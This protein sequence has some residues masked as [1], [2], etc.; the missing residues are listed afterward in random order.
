MKFRNLGRYRTGGTSSKME[1]SVP[2]PKTPEGRVYRFSPNAAAHPRHFVI[3][4]R[5]P[6][7][8]PTEAA[9][10]RMKNEPGSKRTVCPYS[11]MIDADQ[12]FSHPDDIK[13]A[14]EIVGHAAVS[15]MQDELTR[16]FDGL[17][18]RQ[19][20]NSF[21]RIEAK[22]D[23][24]HRPK[25]RFSRR[26]LMRALVCDHCGRDYGVFAIG[27]FCPDCGAPN[28]RLHFAREVE[29][30]GAQIDLA[31]GSGEGQDEL[32]YR[33]LGNAHEDVLTA[34]EATLK[35]VYLHGMDQ[36]GPDAPA[37]KPVK[38]DFQ[39]IERSRK[40][41]A[42]LDFD[43]FD[44]LGE[45]ELATLGLNIQ[46]RHLIGHNL[47]VMDERFA[48]FDEDARI[49]ETVHLVADDIRAFAAIGQRVID[50]LDAWLGGGASPTIGEA[51]LKGETVM[52]KT[53][54]EPSSEEARL[55]TLDLELSPLARRVGLWIARNCPDGMRQ[56]A[57]GEKVRAAF[58][59]SE[60]A[61]LAEALAELETD[62]F[63]T[64]SRG[65]G[66]RIP[67]IRPTVDLYATF[68]PIAVGFD[69]VADAVT[70]TE[71]VLAGDD[72]VGVPELC[73]STGWPHRRFNPALALVVANVGDG[74]VSRTNDGEFPTRS[75]FLL[76]EDR[77]ALKR[78]ATKL[79]R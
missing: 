58:E 46:K 25:P 37:F 16:M 40:R 47:G 75:F 22:V 64:S 62:G 33:L 68:D 55:K 34:F 79:A 10:A 20:R 59:A 17:N 5:R 78:F 48:D 23:K 39:N 4:D 42:D 30:V 1:L 66:P 29:L 70:L 13:A 50:R 67:S 52:S 6:G 76:A 69:P 71:R 27:L 8:E 9:K 63:V 51:P 18:R 65:L 45:G 11:G 21:I 32:A 60:E 28:L 24:R 31:E 7:F 35:A 41:F 12:S 14:K 15:D 61:D 3:G 26:D 53:S 56:F 77:V 43:P 73:A 49:G 2:L 72:S 57:N 44:G 19:S 74:R 36:R 38:N 54:P